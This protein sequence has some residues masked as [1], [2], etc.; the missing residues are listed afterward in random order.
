LARRGQRVLL[1]SQAHT[2]VDNALDKLSH[3][4]SLRVVRLARNERKVTEDGA[5][6]AGQA[7]LQRYYKAL[8]AQTEDRLAVWKRVDEDLRLLLVWRD[9][10]AFVLHDEKELN[11]KR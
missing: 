10:A 9:R 3:D 6:F 11:A 1:A 8:A 4:G 7:S 2:A 5:A